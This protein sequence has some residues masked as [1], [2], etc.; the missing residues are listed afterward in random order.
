MTITEQNRKFMH[1]PS[2]KEGMAASDQSKG[3]TPPPWGKSY[4][5][6]KIT[7]PTWGAPPADSYNALL[8]SRRSVRK[9]ADTPMSGAELA[10]YLW[11]TQGIQS[12]RAEVATFR[13][14]PSGG[15][16]HPFE[17][18]L[19][20]RRVEG[21]APGLYYYA[22]AENIGEKLVTLIKIGEL[23]SDETLT[24]SVA[25]QSWTEGAPVIAYY[26]CVPYK[27]E[28]RYANMAHRVVLIDLGHLGQNAMLSAAAL[29]LGSC[30][31]AAYDQQAA[32]AIFGF[33]GINEYVVYAISI[34]K[35]AQ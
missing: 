16:R 15:A 5:G 7:L 9:Y 17:T 18:Y 14:V 8:D 31:M 27:A 6:E 22:P 11:S 2:F 30:C 29:G 10:F 34:G 19:A 26:S 35:E 33:D 4:D 24:Q 3:V 12:V 25:G 23:P 32:D 21:L 28:W 20:V 13:P 1:C